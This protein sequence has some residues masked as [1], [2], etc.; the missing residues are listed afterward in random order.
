MKE[1]E[2]SQKL[3]QVKNEC[4]SILNEI[5]ENSK[6]NNIEMINYILSKHLYEGYVTIEDIEDKVKN[7]LVNFVTDLKKHYNEQ[8]FNPQSNDE[9]ELKKFVIAEK[10][11]KHLNI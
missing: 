9:N 8:N 5:E 4:K 3:E 10:I 2:V 7:D 1:K 6:K 11:S